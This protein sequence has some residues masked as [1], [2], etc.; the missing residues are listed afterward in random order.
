MIWLQVI[1]V[2]S[3]II[4]GTRLKGISLGI[5]GGLGL[6]ILAFFFHLQP[7]EPPF[8]VLLI[9]T[10]VITAAGTLEAAGGLGY[11]SS[12]AEKAI[13]K[14][15]HR[16]TF[17]APLITYI[18]TFLVG[19]GHII[20]SILPIIAT[21]AKETGIRPER[22]LTTSVIAAQQAAM[23]SPISAPTAILIGLLAPHGIELLDML[24]ILIP[25]TLGGMLITTLVINKTGK[26]LSEEPGYA[27]F[28]KTS[29][30]TNHNNVS[31]PLSKVT[32]SAKLSVILFGVGILFI[33]LLGAFKGLRPSWEKSGKL[34]PMDMSIVIAIMM[35]SIAA[36]IVLICKLKPTEI[37]KASVFTGGIQAVISIL[38]ISWLGDTF[39]NANQAQIMEL[40]QAQIL[41]HPWQ[42]SIILFCMS[43]LLVSQTATIRALIPLGLTL[44]IPALTLLAAVPA[45]N[46][47]F[48]I[49]NYPTLLAATNL[50]STGTTRIGKYILNHSFMLP[51]LIATSSAVL[52]AFGL[53]KYLF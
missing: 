17:I 9:I 31:T 8:C 46:G 41:K 4:I 34:I 49:P 25:A 10:S 35:L 7:T 6:A 40:V 16:I 21:V 18:F 39:V 36:L 27:E 30:E 32:T 42:F 53:V 19:T 20:Y 2:L 14:Y 13:K 44:G 26:E 37:T 52:I 23:A 38:G 22:P 43:I 12:L 5:M 24:C 51:G 48:F 50:D 33:I 47:L 29:Q 3:A 28:L 45:V 1:V 11:L 15:P